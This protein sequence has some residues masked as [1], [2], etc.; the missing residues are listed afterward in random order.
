MSEI[1]ELE[2][3]IEFREVKDHVIIRVR[4]EVIGESSTGKTE[5]WANSHGWVNIPD[6][7]IMLNLMMGTKKGKPKAKPKGKASKETLEFI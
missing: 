1:K 2:E 5:F 7:N 3:G 4:K 6:T